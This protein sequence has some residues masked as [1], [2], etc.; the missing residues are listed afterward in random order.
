MKKVNKDEHKE[1]D[2]TLDDSHCNEKVDIK[3][4]YHEV[5]DNMHITPSTDTLQANDGIMSITNDAGKV[6]YLEM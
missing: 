1:L 2:I 5:P 6:S 4:P 3:M